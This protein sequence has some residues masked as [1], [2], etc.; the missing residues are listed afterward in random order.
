MARATITDWRPDDDRFWREGGKKVARRN[1]KW[2]IFAEFLGFSVWQ[3][4]SV[5][6]VKLPDAGFDF[7]TAQLFWLI[8]IPGLVGATMRFP[9]TFAPAR[10]GGRTWTVVSALLLLIPSIG[11]A[12]A[13]SNPATPY[14]AF[15]AL[16]A[17]AGFGGGNF[18]SSMANISFFYPEKH[19]GTALGL[20]AAGGNLGVAVVQKLVPWV[21]GGGLIGGAIVG[22]STGK[23]GLYLQ[24]AG[25]IY[26]PLI[27]FAAVMAWRRMDNLAGA[28]SSVREQARALRRKYCWIV[29]ALYI[30]AFGSFIGYS[31]AL[32]L[33]VKT[34]FPSVDPLA[35][36]FLG[37]LVG[38]LA[39][40]AGGWLSDRIGGAR[41]T[42]AAFAG[43]SMGVP[44]VLLA[45]HAGSFDGFLAAMML[46]FVL[47][48][49]ANGSVFRMVPHLARK[50]AVEDVGA[51]EHALVIAR[52]EGAAVIGFSAAIAAYGGF[53]IPEGFKRSLEATGEIDGAFYVFLGYY[54]VCLSV[55]W[56]YFVRRSFAVRWAPSLADV[57]A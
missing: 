22:G 5:T 46:L 56:W 1:L 27:L 54:A 55:T 49:V 33:V 44:V 3:L 29:T 14:W 36:A 26:V 23:E 39:R 24:N 37:P 40:P 13:V 28:R 32:P 6:A 34:Q 18:S 8:S 7:T 38:S 51:G 25:L 21:I 19:K 35:Y 48:G 2:S 41:V 31:A 43:M 4:W 42:L 47:A 52:R 30:G 11:L 9:Y 12:V 17:T 15:L 16:A 53:L 50:A 57:R 20:N 45:L 10:Y